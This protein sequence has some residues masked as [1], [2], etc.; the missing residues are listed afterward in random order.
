M[1]IF[2]AGQ[3]SRMRA[4]FSPGGYRASLLNSPACGPT[5]PTIPEWQV[6]QIFSSIN[7]EYIALSVCTVTVLAN[8]VSA[9]DRAVDILNST[10]SP[11]SM[12]AEA[13]MIVS[14]L[15]ARFQAVLPEPVSAVTVDAAP[16]V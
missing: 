4:Q 15:L 14:L 12:S 2:T 6:N 8:C 1:N 10:C 7:F 9:A 5:Q 13:V 16:P 3:K 11:D